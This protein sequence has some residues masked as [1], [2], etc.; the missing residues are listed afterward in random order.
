MKISTKNMLIMTAT[1]VVIIILIIVIVNMNKSSD[2]EQEPT[3]EEDDTDSTTS[4]KRQDLPTLPSIIKTIFNEMP[5]V[6]V[7]QD[8]ILQSYESKN[9]KSKAIQNE[10]GTITINTDAGTGY[11]YTAVLTMVDNEFTGK[12][13][14]YTITYAM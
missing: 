5:S 2:S 13:A 7:L 10:D 1:V 4:F 3:P 14:G 6:L 9:V 8:N 11:D 12:V